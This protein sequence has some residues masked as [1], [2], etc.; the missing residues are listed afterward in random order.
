[1]CYPN[2][3]PLCKKAGILIC[4]LFTAFAPAAQPDSLS[5]GH[6]PEY[7]EDLLGRSPEAFDF[8]DIFENP[9]RNR[10]KPL[11]LND[12]TESELRA[13]GLLSEP[14]I[15][16]F[17][18]YREK[19]G[20]LI[21]V[22]ELQAVPGF[23]TGSIRRILPYIQVGG[24]PDDFQVGIGDMLRNGRNEAQV[25]WGRFLEI[26]E[27][28]IAGAGGKGYLG[29]PNQLFFRY[30]KTYYNRFSWGIVGDKDRG[31]PYT[32]A[33]LSFYSAHLFLSRYNAWL[34]ALAIGDYRLSAGQGLIATPG[35]GYGKSAYATTI[36]R[37]APPLRPH[38]SA[39]E[40]GF[41][42]GIAATLAVTG[43]LTCTPF[44]SW[45]KRDGSLAGKDSAG[46]WSDGETGWT[47]SLSDAGLHRTAAEIAG[48]GS[49]RHGVAGILL[50]YRHNSV[51]LGLNALYHR[52]NPGFSP[53][54]RVYNRFFFRGEQLTNLSIEYAFPIGAAHFFGETAHSSN[55]A[56]A[57][58]HGVRFSP[59]KV[60]DIALH[61][62]HFPRDYQAIDAAPFADGS[63]ARN[64][65]GIYTGIA[66]YPVQGLSINAYTDLWQ[67]PWL[68]YAADRPVRGQEYRFRLSFE[69]RKGFLV[70][71]EARHRT[72]EENIRLT[73]AAY[74]Q[75]LPEKILQCRLHLRNPV[76]RHIELR[77]RID[78]GSV[79]SPDG[80]RQQGAMLLQD[81]L[82]RP[83]Q[84][85]VSFT[86]RYAIFSTPGYDLRF[87]HYENDLLN[88]FSIP[89]YFGHGSRVYFNIRVRPLR[90]LSWEFRFA[91]TFRHDGAI[92]GTGPEAFQGN[93]RTQI[94]SQIKWI[95]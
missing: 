41:L 95:F 42:R 20:A 92:I 54:Y 77:T 94:G 45:R 1:M 67:H 66:L 9:G 34:R 27:G 36:R 48:K 80:N 53:Q 55:G 83:I 79:E 93:R 60:A 52:L 71:A 81:I 3:R 21:S 90:G 89:A 32:K 84:S 40:S 15:L 26:Q 61:V 28:Y 85:P 19:A 16:N 91:Q 70:Y 64:E 58:V 69:K 7:I 75:P 50:Q 78:W 57:T 14:Q 68:R 33:G 49:L 82:Y 39:G 87:Y 43:R 22:Y 51:Q 86:A 4:G 25:R 8:P 74:N 62:R 12:A 30:R 47:S 29:D 88:T 65:T 6:E 5:D 76:G 59:D 18:A 73:G 38:A 17:I 23:D 46:T 37:G 13:L 72:T 35:F 10:A 31:E 2:I 24:T 56:I 63:G 44:L 11:K